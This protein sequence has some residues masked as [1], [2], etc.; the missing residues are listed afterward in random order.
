MDM[1]ITLGI[2]LPLMLR[3]LIAC[4]LDILDTT[5]HSHPL[6]Q[7]T[8]QLVDTTRILVNPPTIAASVATT[9]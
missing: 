4:T 7:F 6:R 9:P 5:S 3:L 8:I 2:M 1:L